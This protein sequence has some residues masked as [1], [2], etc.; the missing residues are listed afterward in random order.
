MSQ[1]CECTCGCCRYELEAEIESKISDVRIIYGHKIA[2]LFELLRQEAT[3]KAV[4]LSEKAY[5]RARAHDP[6]PFIYPTMP[7]PLYPTFPTNP[8]WRIG[9]GQETYK[10]A[11]GDSTTT[12]PTLLPF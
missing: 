2:D 3:Q 1:T 8:P 11:I 6:V 10:I 12:V 4:A 9:D 5:E 7:A